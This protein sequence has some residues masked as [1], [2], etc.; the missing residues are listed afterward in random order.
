M[1]EPGPESEVTSPERRGFIL[2]LGAMSLL[3]LAVEGSRPQPGYVL[4]ARVLMSALLLSAPAL[5][6]RPLAPRAVR[7]VVYTVC[8]GVCLAFGAIAWGT[9]GTH[10]AYFAFLPM[11]PLVFTIAVPDVPVGSLVAGVCAG[12][13][14]LSRVRLEGLPAQEAMFWVLAFSATTIYAVAA[15]VFARRQRAR[16]RRL[17]GERARAEEV[18]A[19]SERQRGRAER[20]AL[21]GR[22]AAGVARDVAEPIAAV[23]ARLRDLEH[24]A[25]SAGGDAEL[26]AALAGVRGALDRIRRTVEDLRRLAREDLEASEDCDLAV[27]AQEAR[28]ALQE[29]FRATVSFAPDLG[30]ELPRVHAVHGRLVHALVW[31]LVDASGRRVSGIRLAAIRD[32]D[33]VTV[34]LFERRAGLATAPLDLPAAA[35]E[36]AGLALELAREELSRSGCELEIV[37]PAG[38]PGP[39]L[40]IRCAAGRAVPARARV[41]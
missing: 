38:A 26:P 28:L 15:A 29:R 4:A 39:W 37:D 40:K 1:R 33:R 18:L 3:F 21:A 16:E 32:G 9:G 34:E 2:V 41:A 14:G 22:L 24:R 35:V 12:G 20:L 7:A 17:V 36:E 30:A 19:E 5:L 31:I 11:L 13:V 8:G 10:G 6:A 27:V 23:T 25:A